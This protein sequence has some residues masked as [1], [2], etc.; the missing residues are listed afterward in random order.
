MSSPRKAP[1]ITVRRLSLYFRALDAALR[2]GRKQISSGDLAERIQSSSA[3]VRRDLSSFGSFGTRGHGYEIA[4]LRE[5]LRAILGLDRTWNT[6]VVGAGRLGTA[7][8]SHGE[9]ERQGF[10]IVALFDRDPEKIGEHVG[11]CSIFAL[12]QLEPVVQSE[13][14]TLGVITT[15]AEA[16]QESADRL[17]QAGVRGIL[18]FAPVP[19]IVPQRIHARHVNLTIELEGLSFA[20]VEEETKRRRLPKSAGAP[21]RIRP[22]P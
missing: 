19:I 15:P 13:A 22:R 21:P 20:L 17:V 16:A 7:L 1:E 2:E 3:Q 4:S 6:A 8:A 12:E 10:R 14:V 11:G 18:N 9:L 5:H